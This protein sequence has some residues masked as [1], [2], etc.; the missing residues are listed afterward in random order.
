MKGYC[1]HI[2][3]RSVNAV[4][5]ILKFNDLTFMVSGFVNRWSSVR[6][7]LSAPPSSPCWSGSEGGYAVFMLFSTFGNERRILGLFGGV[8]VSVA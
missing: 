4:F 6:I 1:K 7:R 3:E 5:H 8:F 2:C